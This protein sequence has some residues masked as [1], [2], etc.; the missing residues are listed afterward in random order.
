MDACLRD[1]AAAERY[2]AQGVERGLQVFAAYCT[3]RMPPALL[4]PKP[5]LRIF[6]VG[7]QLWQLR[8]F[9]LLFV[10]WCILVARDWIRRR[11]A[12]S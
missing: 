7:I 11:V 6:G 12:A 3:D 4:P 5:V 8:V 2:Y 9:G 1:K 10:F